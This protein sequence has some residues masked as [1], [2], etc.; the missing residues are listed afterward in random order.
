MKEQ[1]KKEY[2]VK[3]LMKEFVKDIKKALEEL[4]A[5]SKEIVIEK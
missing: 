3:I 1:D 2:K 4:G 5:K